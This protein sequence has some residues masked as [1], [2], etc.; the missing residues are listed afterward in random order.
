MGTEG[1]T[2]V[3][4]GTVEGEEHSGSS[5]SGSS[6]SDGEDPTP[7]QTPTQTPQQAP[8]MPLPTPTQAPAQPSLTVQKS[9]QKLSSPPPETEHVGGHAGQEARQVFKES[10]PKPGNWTRGSLLGAGAYGSVYMG[11]TDVYV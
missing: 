3:E 11:L 2:N 4:G 1:S 5:E 8:Q 6:C 9:Q 10:V 7:T